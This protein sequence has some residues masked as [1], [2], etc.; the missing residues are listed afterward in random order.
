MACIGPA[1]TQRGD[2]E[3]AAGTD[4]LASAAPISIGATGCRSRLRVYYI[5]PIVRRFDLD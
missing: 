2:R 3:A 4:H 1:A 5:Q